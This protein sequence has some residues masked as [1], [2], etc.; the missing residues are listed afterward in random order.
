MNENGDTFC[1]LSFTK[2]GLCTCSSSDTPFRQVQSPPTKQPVQILAPTSPKI[3]TNHPSSTV[4]TV[5]CKS[6]CQDPCDWGWSYGQSVC[7]EMTASGVCGLAQINGLCYCTLDHVVPP[8]L[9]PVPASAPAPSPSPSEVES[10][11]SWNPFPTMAWLQFNPIKFNPIH[12]PD[13]AT[14]CKRSCVHPCGWSQSNGESFCCETSPSG[15]S[16]TTMNGACY[17]G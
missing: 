14:P 1:A 2:E 6:S 9:V 10:A 17:C 7:C 8:V 5:P 13:N 15:C 4:E 3:N 11:S 16:M 12:V